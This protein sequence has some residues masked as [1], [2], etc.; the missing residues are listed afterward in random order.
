MNANGRVNLI[1]PNTAK[2]FSLYDKIPIGKSTPFLNA[3]KGQQD[4]TQLSLVYFSKENIQIVHNAIR[5]GVHQKSRGRFTIGNQNIDTLK[6]IMRS[7]Y[8]Q[9]AVNDTCKITEQI[10]A[11]NKM[12]A[13]FSIPQ[14]LG[15]VESYVKY[16]VD[17][18]TLA[19]P[20]ARPAYMSTAGSNTLELKPFF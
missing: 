19:V 15:E 3:L 7:I 12:V 6:I 1:Q 2:Q 11:L 16:K 9:N 10:Q 18:S 13:D 20:L 14:I 5:S 17:V 8:L 4:V